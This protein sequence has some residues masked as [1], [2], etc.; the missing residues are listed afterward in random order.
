M[1]SE[2]IIPSIRSSK[3]FFLSKPHKFSSINMISL[4]SNFILYLT[5]WN[6]DEKQLFNCLYSYY[7][8]YKNLS[9]SELNSKFQF[10]SFSLY[11]LG[12]FNNKYKWKISSL[13][14]IP[15]MSFR[16]LTFRF[17]GWI[18]NIKAKT[19]KKLDSF[20]FVKN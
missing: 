20:C 3:P 4:N 16:I 19:L 15:T 5:V 9:L 14:K 8:H 7:L 13:M 10:S 2:F 17:Y 12:Y 1:A 18:E 11:A 6:D